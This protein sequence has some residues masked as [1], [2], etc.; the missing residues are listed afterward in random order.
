MRN[1]DVPGLTEGVATDGWLIRRSVRHPECFGMLF[2]RHAGL[3]HR[4]LA[5]R[6]GAQAADDLLAEVFLAAF[7]HRDRYESTRPDAR[8]W[9]YGIAGH[10]VAGHRREEA[11]RWRLLAALPTGPDE[12][13]PATA[14]ADRA[15]AQLA[16]RDLAGALA[17]L[18]TDER[19]ALLL[20][21]WEDLSYAQIAEA[22]DVPIGT[23]RSRI[24]RARQKLRPQLSGLGLVAET[25]SKEIRTP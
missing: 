9:L 19:A 22:L 3:I 15:T 14:A 20:L 16:G 21:A 12:P 25:D 8:P 13:D 6:L 4:Y 7:R 23:V 11:R 5:R 18:N 24:S 17:A 10:V 2:D 1:L